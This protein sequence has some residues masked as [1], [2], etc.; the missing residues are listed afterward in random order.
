MPE[1]RTV[2]V[3]AFLLLQALLMHWAAGREH[4]PAMPDLSRFPDQFGAWTKNHEDPISPDVSVALHADQLLSRTYSDG[5]N[6]AGLLV[7][8]FQSQRG[9]ASQPHSPKV[10]LPGSG[11]TPQVTDEV[12]VDTSVGPIR[13]NRYIVAYQGQRIV[14]LYWYQTPRRV[15]AGEWA[16]KLWLVNDALRDGRTDTSLVRITVWVGQDDRTAT[17]TAIAFAK[18][19]FPRLREYLPH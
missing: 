16:A 14:V 10:C 4:P 11:W 3:P 17:N 7:A 9:G 13:I 19:L 18:D 2:L 5:A 15:I 6:Q 1:I 8:W 12:T